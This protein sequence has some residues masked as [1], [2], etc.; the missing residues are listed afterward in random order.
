MKYKNNL[1]HFLG[2]DL[3]YQV[4]YNVLFFIFNLFLFM[5][6]EKLGVQLN[7]GL[8]LTTPRLKPELKSRV[9]H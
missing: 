4:R 1:H 6:F 5:Y 9:E 8:E 2:I 3:L 7:S